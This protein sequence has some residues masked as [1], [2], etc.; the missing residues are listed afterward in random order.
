[1]DV[2]GAD[3]A[4]KVILRT[5]SVLRSP[6]DTIKS[7]HTALVDIVGADKA[8]EAI[9]QLQTIAKPWCAGDSC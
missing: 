5:V 4:A 9:L 1:M 6:G 3:N 2:L 8:A 7:A